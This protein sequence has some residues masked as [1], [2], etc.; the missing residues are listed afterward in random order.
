MAFGNGGGQL[1]WY[2]VNQVMAEVTLSTG[3]TAESEV[4]SP[5]TWC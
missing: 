1:R 4:A 5:R 2:K 3:N